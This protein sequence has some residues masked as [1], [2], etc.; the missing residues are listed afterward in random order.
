MP[1]IGNTE[2]YAVMSASGPTLIAIWPK[3]NSYDWC[4]EHTPK[5]EG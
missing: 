2:S 5:G 1:P 4:G 3:V